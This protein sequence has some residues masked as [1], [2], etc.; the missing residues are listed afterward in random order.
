MHMFLFS[1][2]GINIYFRKG[3]VFYVLNNWVQTFNQSE[4]R[5]MH[6]YQHL[7]TCGKVS[8]ETKYIL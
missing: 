1:L 3:F 4:I 2:S 6:I 7:K 5:K 8:G